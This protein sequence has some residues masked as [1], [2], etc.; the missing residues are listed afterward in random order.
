MLLLD[1]LRRKHR[2]CCWTN[3]TFSF[4]FVGLIHHKGRYRNS[5][6]QWL[7][8]IS[9]KYYD[10][11]AHNARLH[12]H[13]TSLI[14]FVR[15]QYTSATNSPECVTW[16]HIPR[17]DPADGTCTEQVGDRKCCWLKTEKRAATSLTETAG[18][19]ICI[20]RYACYRRRPKPRPV[21]I[22]PQP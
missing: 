9:C 13:L 1:L 18:C 3:I 2:D 22:L 4:R 14:C 12:G 16:W 10:K 8:C 17:L 7:I 15:V 19:S 20:R 11:P 6:Q 5:N 21:V